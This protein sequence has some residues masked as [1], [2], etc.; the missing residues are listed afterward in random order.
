[1]KLICTSDWHLRATAPV[2]RID[3]DYFET[4]K[5]KGQFIFDYALDNGIK[6]ILHG[7]DLFDTPIV[8]DR[9]KTWLA[10]E[11]RTIKCYT[12]LGQHDLSMRRLI[13]NSSIA[14]MIES[15]CIKR[16]DLFLPYKIEDNVHIYGCSW[17]GEIPEIVNKDVY[18]ILIIHKMISDK[19]Y[20]HGHVEYTTA[21]KFM[22]DHKF[23]LIISGDNHNSFEHKMVGKSKER[24]LLNSGSL[25]R[26]RI[27]QKDHKPCFYVVDTDERKVLKI[28]IPVKP[29]EDVFNFVEAIKD[30]KRNEELDKFIAEFESSGWVNSIDIKERAR[31]IIESD[32]VDDWCKMIILEVIKEI[33]ENESIN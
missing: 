11:F 22:T 14:V 31:K 12:V 30:E 9:I 16:T 5:E 15:E 20:W 4:L 6:V 3:S 28:F 1:M 19:D 21:K 33:E 7:A 25:C 2:N 27:D 13:D 10:R 24:Y 17:E 23:D 8:P 29:A 32:D 26:A 18:N